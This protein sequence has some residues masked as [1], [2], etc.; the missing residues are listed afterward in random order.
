M[1]Q[2]IRALFLAMLCWGATLT[3]CATPAQSQTRDPGPTTVGEARQPT[4][5]TTAPTVAPAYPVIDAPPDDSTFVCSP[6][7][8]VCQQPDAWWE[9]WD[10]QQS[11]DLVTYRFVPGLVTERRFVDEILF[12]WQWP[13]GRQLLLMASQPHLLIV[14]SPL[15]PSVVDAPGTHILGQFNSF[16]RTI[17]VAEAYT[18]TSTVWLADT[19]SHELQHAAD[20]GMGWYQEPTTADC[21]SREQRA[22]H[23]E[24]AYVGWL[25]NRFGPLPERASVARELSPED[26]QLF[27]LI[28]YLSTAQQLDADTARTYQAACGVS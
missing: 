21:L 3:A 27:D 25:V 11:R 19:I 10:D 5:V 22:R 6:P 20:A 7:N 12:L 26:N 1:S 13:I 24:Q 28:T 18:K 9:R 16:S 17:T 4:G 8:P 14:G 23:V 15:G 2:A